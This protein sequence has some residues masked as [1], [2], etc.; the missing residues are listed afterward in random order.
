MTD[1]IDKVTLSIRQDIKKSLSSPGVG[2]DE[3]SDGKVERAG[4]ERDR[5]D[6]RLPKD[7]DGQDISSGEVCQGCH[8]QN[9]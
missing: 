1:K 9:R 3:K 2:D 7:F 6:L 5:K 8:R 4:E